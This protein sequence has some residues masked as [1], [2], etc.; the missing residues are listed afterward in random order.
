MGDNYLQ[1]QQVVVEI[2]IFFLL[3]PLAVVGTKHI[4]FMAREG[5]HKHLPS[6]ICCNKREKKSLC[7]TASN[8]WQRQ[9]RAE[10][11]E[12]VCNSTDANTQLFLQIRS[13]W[14]VTKPRCSSTRKHLTCLLL[15]S[16]P[17]TGRER[18][19]TQLLRRGMLQQTHQGLHKH[20]PPRGCITELI[21]SQEPAN[22]NNTAQYSQTGSTSSTPYSVRKITC[23]SDRLIN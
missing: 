1:T 17:D 13:Y 2:A 9:V 19:P 7:V 21:H 23:W 15:S 6:K 20:C 18:G 11:R 5:V 12:G 4:N 10:S 3:F 16:G 8:Q 14:R 22:I